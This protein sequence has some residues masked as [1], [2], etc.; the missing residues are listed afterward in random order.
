M[1]AAECLT[2]RPKPLI[3]WT[4]EASR[5]L[6]ASGG[7]SCSNWSNGIAS[8]S[9]CPI[10]TLASNVCCLSNRELPRRKG[11]LSV[12]L[13]V[14]RQKRQPLATV[15]QYSTT[16]GPQCT[17]AL[18]PIWR[19][20]HNHESIGHESA[21]SPVPTFGRPLLRG[22]GNVETKSAGAPG[23]RSWTNS[24]A[25]ITARTKSVGSAV[26]SPGSSKQS[27][28]SRSSQRG[29]AFRPD[30]PSSTSRGPRR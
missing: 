8:F 2:R 27:L 14:N 22:W 15:R 5:M 24:S 12:K 13:S 9:E 4:H 29:R 3:L 7:E 17:H 20:I 18:F 30:T 23:K 21:V 19:T 11:G 25:P 28:H 1:R 6:R 10:P 16:T 26:P